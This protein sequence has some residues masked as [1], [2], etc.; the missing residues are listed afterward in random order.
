MY[1]QKVE[2]VS[3]SVENVSPPS[4]RHPAVLQRRPSK[5]HQ[6]AHSKPSPILLLLVFAGVAFVSIVQVSPTLNNIKKPMIVLV[7][8]EMLL[9]VPVRLRVPQETVVRKN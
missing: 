9:P 1:H 5:R 6:A 2:N 7:L 3:P 8:G 4:K